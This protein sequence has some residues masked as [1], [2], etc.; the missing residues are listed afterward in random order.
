VDG[1]QK[2]AYQATIYLHSS[3]TFDHTYETTIYDRESFVGITTTVTESKTVTEFAYYNVDFNTVGINSSAFTPFD[4]LEEDQVLQ[5]CF[6]AHEDIETVLI[7]IQQ[8]PELI[9]SGMIQHSLVLN[10]FLHYWLSIGFIPE[11]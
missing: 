7:P 4:D 9:R 8:V 1:L 5:W 6:D 2:V 3:T 10:A 11:V